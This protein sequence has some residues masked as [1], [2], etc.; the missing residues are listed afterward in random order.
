M[1]VEQW[2]QENFQHDFD[3]RKLKDVVS[4]KCIEISNEIR[5]RYD[6]LF[7]STLVAK[8]NEQNLLKDG[9]FEALMSSEHKK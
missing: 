8:L 3:N 1:S 6:L 9:V 4:Q 2:I 5:D 7:A